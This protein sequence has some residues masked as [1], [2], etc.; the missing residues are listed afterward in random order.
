VPDQAI[1]EMAGRLTP[2]S[3]DEGFTRVIVVA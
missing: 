1:L 2:P 3:I